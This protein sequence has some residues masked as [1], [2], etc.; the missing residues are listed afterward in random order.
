MQA[1]TEAGAYVATQVEKPQ[2]TVFTDAGNGVSQRQVLQVPTTREEMQALLSQREEISNQLRSASARRDDI[3]E[4]L[5]TVPDDA[6]PGLQSQLQ[7]LDV[8][9]VQLEKDLARLGQ[10]ISG[11]SP[12]LLRS[13][14]DRPRPSP[15]PDVRFQQGLVSAGVPIFVIMSAVFFF[16]HRW[17]KRESRRATAALPSADSERLQRVENGMEAMAIEIERI[18]EGQRF[19]TKLLSE[20]RSTEPAP[21]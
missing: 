3:I 13:S 4:K 6:R 15:S 21:R 11:A 18:S 2:I 5:R 16:S 19:V 14:Y 8:R 20:S 12:Q 17:W 7:V 9:V 1:P 10:E